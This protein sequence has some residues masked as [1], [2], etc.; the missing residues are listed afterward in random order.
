MFKFTVFSTM[1]NGYSLIHLDIYV[2]L[3]KK[4]KVQCSQLRVIDIINLV[5]I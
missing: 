5:K 4:I 1:L 3:K 2:H